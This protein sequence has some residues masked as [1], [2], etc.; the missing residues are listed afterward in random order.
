MPIAA[1]FIVIF[2][3]LMI[4]ILITIDNGWW[5][6]S[7]LALALLIAWLLASFSYEKEIKKQ[8][9]YTSSRVDNTDIIV[10][11]D[12]IINLN[13]KLKK[14]IEPGTKI[15]HIQYYTMYGGIDY[16][17]AKCVDDKFEIYKE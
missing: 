2:A 15:D 5:P 13:E 11:K 1:M 8:T 16:S 7:T 3:L 14:V 4:T 9:L 6:I 10:L 12:D 17:E